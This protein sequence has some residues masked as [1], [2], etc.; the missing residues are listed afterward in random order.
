MAIVLRNVRICTGGQTTAPQDLRIRQGVIESIGRALPAE[1]DDEV[2][3]FQ[4]EACVSAGWLDIGVQTGDPG[5]EHR[6]DLHS[7]AQAAIAGGFTALA[8]FPNT[9]PA[10]DSKSGIVYLQNKTAGSIVGFH[11]IGALSVHAEGKDLAELYD[12]HTAGAVAFS[13]GVQ[14]IQDAGLLLRALEYVKAFDGLVIHQPQHK[15]L[16]AGGQMH[17]GVV[18]TM[19]G[20]KGLPALAEE[21]TVQRDL[22][23]LEYAGSRLHLHLLSSRKSV[24]LVR[25][26]KAAGLPVTASVAVANLCFTDEVMQEFDSHWKVLP[27]LRSADDR[28]ALLE[29]LADGTIDCICSNHTPWDIE[30]KNLEFPYA[31]FGMIG[32]ETAFALCRTY[33]GD[34]F[35]FPD[36]VE[37]WALGSRRVLGLPVPEIRPGAVAELTIFAPDAEWTFSAQDIRS[38]SHNTPFVGQQ[39]TGRVLGVVNKGQAL[40]REGV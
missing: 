35:R 11:P 23:L 37:K 18:S 15:T 9:L 27:P 3:A 38:R 2:W 5:F 26:A 25:A 31:Q 4:Q 20:L 39:F 22:S 28:E 1:P 8:C 13:D 12:M 21:V 14:P 40:R 32:L 30:A 36:L 24:A 17:E 29:G 10:V 6:E 19:L 33:L 34:R 7:V 16:A